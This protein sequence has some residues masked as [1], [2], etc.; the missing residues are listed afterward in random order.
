[1]ERTDEK[2]HYHIRWSGRTAL[3]WES[4][5][6]RAEAE[7]NANQLRRRGETYTIEEHN[8]SCPRCRDAMKVKSASSNEASV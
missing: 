2:P 1:M 4:F 7:A 6:T 8:Q 5:A 3:D